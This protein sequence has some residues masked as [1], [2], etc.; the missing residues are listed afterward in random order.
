MD[1]KSIGCDHS[2]IVQPAFLI[3]TYDE[4]GTA[5]FAPITWVSITWDTNHYVLVISMFGSKK[6]KTNALH[7]KMLSVNLVSTDMLNLMEYFG[8][9]SGEEGPK[10]EAEYS[11]SEGQVLKVPTLDCSKWVYECEVVNT[12][13]TGDSHTFFCDVK[14]VQVDSGINI[15]NG[16]DLTEFS[17]VIYS[18]HYH[19]IG[20][21]LGKLGDFYKK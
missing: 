11:Y 19:S 14:N 15:E 12:V 3:G 4:N 13:Q 17:P 7:S 18:G 20:S 16:I 2:M 1:R 6:T 10:R 21:H 5:N 8:N 9:C